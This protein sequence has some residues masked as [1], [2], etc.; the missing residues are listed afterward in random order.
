M[1]VRKALQRRSGNFGVFVFLGRMTAFEMAV[2]CGLKDLKSTVACLGRG[3]GGNPK[4]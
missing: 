3:P 4:P 2:P 1:D